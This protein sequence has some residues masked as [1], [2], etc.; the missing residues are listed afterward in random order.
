MGDFAEVERMIAFGWLLCVM[1]FKSSILFIS[2]FVHPPFQ[3]AKH[4]ALPEFER[5]LSQ[6]KL[7]MAAGNPE[8]MF[9]AQIQKT[10]GKTRWC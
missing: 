3:R 10:Q 5:Y 7:S 8:R 1:I 2:G 9:H 6:H 4:K